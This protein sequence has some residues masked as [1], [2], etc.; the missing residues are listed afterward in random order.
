[1]EFLASPEAQTIYAE[2]NYEY[3]IAPG[4]KPSEL[5]ASWGTFTA[6]D[7]NLMEIAKLRGVALRMIEEVD[8]DG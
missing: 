7:V 6:D 5:V 1:M 4:T 2:Q 3:P 8:F